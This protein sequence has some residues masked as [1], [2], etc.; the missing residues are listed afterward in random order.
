LR[1]IPHGQD[2]DAHV[3]SNPA[4][5]A[6]CIIALLAMA[7]PSMPKKESKQSLSEQYFGQTTETH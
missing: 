3:L 4:P 1:L 6:H 7:K 5:V 2:A